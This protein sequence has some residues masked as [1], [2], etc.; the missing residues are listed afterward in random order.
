M[1]DF[2]GLGGFRHGV[3]KMYPFRGISNKYVPI[4]TVERALNELALPGLGYRRVSVPNF[5]TGQPAIG[6]WNC[7]ALANALAKLIDPQRLERCQGLGLP[8]L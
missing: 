4:E 2:P 5:R 7:Y 3:G 1:G 8:D 6:L